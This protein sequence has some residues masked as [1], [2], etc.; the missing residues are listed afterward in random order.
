[1][2][3]DRIRSVRPILRAAAVAAFLALC[4]GVA[5]AADAPN[6]EVNIPPQEPATAS[7][8]TPLGAAKAKVGPTTTTTKLKAPA[9]ACQTPNFVEPACVPDARQYRD[10]FPFLPDFFG[11]D[12]PRDGC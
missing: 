12:S 8:L 5:Y 1:M 3:N 9:T 2:A 6:N 4:G 10:L 7:K 11:P